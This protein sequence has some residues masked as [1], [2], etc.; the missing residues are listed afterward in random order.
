MK[1]SIP[2]R[3]VLKQ[4]ISNYQILYKKI[5]AIAVLQHFNMVVV[6]CIEIKN[7]LLAIVNQLL[8]AIF[9]ALLDY[10]ISTNVKVQHQMDELIDKVS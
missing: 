3:E 2:T 1:Q 7:K 6:N 4:Q 9:Q 10:T 8:S 5:E